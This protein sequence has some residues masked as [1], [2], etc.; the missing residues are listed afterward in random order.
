ML[1]RKSRIFL[2]F[3]EKKPEKQLLYV[4]D[5]HFPA[6]LGSESD[7]LALLRYLEKLG[8]IKCDWSIRNT[9]LAVQLTHEGRNRRFFSFQDFLHYLSEKWI[10]IVA[11]GIS[12]IALVISICAYGR[13]PL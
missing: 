8:Y 1:D 3:L 6:S 10:D 7:F 13:P 9:L 12:I 5:R 11:L 2:K 4:E